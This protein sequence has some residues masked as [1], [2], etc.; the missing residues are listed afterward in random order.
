MSTNFPFFRNL[1]GFPKPPSFPSYAGALRSR[2]RNIGLFLAFSGLLAFSFSE[3]FTVGLPAQEPAETTETS[4]APPKQEESETGPDEIAPVADVE[5]AEN[6]ENT[7]N[8]DPTEFMGLRIR[9][10]VF[11]GLINVRERELRVLRDNNLDQELS[12]E[13]ISNIIIDTFNLEYFA[14][15][16]PAYEK[17]SAKSLRLYIIVEEKKQVS[18]IRFR[19]RSSLLGQGRLKEAIYLQERQ[20]FYEEATVRADERRIEA[21][22]FEKGALNTKVQ[23][24]VEDDTKQSNAVIVTFF[25]NEGE[26][27][28]ITG[29]DFVGSSYSK[30][31]LFSAL[32]AGGRPLNYKTDIFFFPKDYVARNIE[33]DRQTYE[34]FYR[35]EGYLDM[36]IIRVEE[37][38]FRV[39]RTKLKV[40]QNKIA[41]TKY[42]KLVYH[43]DEGP[44]Y[45]YDGVSIEGNELFSEEELSEL[46]P[47]G[48]GEPFN[49]SAFNASLGALQQKY[50]SLGYAQTQVVPVEK[51]DGTK[52]TVSYQIKITESKVRNRIESI[53]IKGN[54]QTKDYVVLREIPLKAGDIFN[55]AE[56]RRGIENLVYTRFFETVD[57]QI[58]QG[59]APGL[60]RII[61]N[62]S[63]G[64]TMNVTA[65]LRITP[66]TTE[67]SFPISGTFQLSENNFLG[68]GY[69]LGTNLELGINAQNVQLKFGNSRVSGSN[70]GIGLSLG[71][72]HS[73]NSGIGQDLDG[74]G[75]LDPFLTKQSFEDASATLISQYLSSYGMR[76]E[77][78][79]INLGINSSLTW[80][81]PIFNQYSRLEFSN[82]YN[83]GIS[84]VDYDNDVFRPLSERSRGNFQTWLFSDTLKFGLGWSTTDVPSEPNRGIS[85]VQRF[86][87]GGLVPADKNIYY[88]Q[89]RSSLDFYVPI[90]EVHASRSD[91]VFRLIFHFGTSFNILLQHPWQ[92]AT[93]DAQI[94]GSQLLR[95]TMLNRGSW[96]YDYGR[97][98]WNTTAEIRYPLIPRVLTIDLF[99]DAIMLWRELSQISST[100]LDDFRF[101]L[102][103]GPRLTIPQLPLAIYVTKN[104][105]SNN[106]SLDGDPEPDN[107]V[108]DQGWAFSF[109]FNI[110]F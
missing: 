54:V 16:E 47:G 99:F 45:N 39:S 17:I 22:Y 65:G 60:I 48:Q 91:Y 42:L 63:E 75:I 27:L 21:A 49:M 108:M 73:Q 26:R 38:L 80:R 19:G 53:E 56:L 100:G 57:P 76:N 14:N 95:Y 61:L 110:Q 3:A 18:N 37:I 86:T 25:I 43:I 96:T 109:V 97:A 105:R 77:T 52:L 106:G 83:T 34:A 72:S 44:R 8:S 50:I 23:S 12:N 87:L 62:V 41:R 98:F 93:P 107:I 92:D 88:L 36:R 33:D 68:R 6:A 10:I 55:G 2:S 9:D 81:I 78:S 71:F 30:S 7:I 79:S 5:N 29:A 40:S 104:F 69:T 94:Y 15:V 51:K 85:L 70:F 74:N 20:S 24:S 89:S 31:K 4:E 82:G 28:R 1:P 59:S 66:S 103:F 67:G 84:Y 101:T 46:F 64:Q 11:Q 58:V 32:G 90:V 13:I 102:G 35:S